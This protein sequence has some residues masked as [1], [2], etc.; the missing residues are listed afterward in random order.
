MSYVNE[1]KIVEAEFLSSWDSVATPVK[2]DNVQ[3]LVSGTNRIASE[4]KLAEWCQLSVVPGDAVQA[5][6]NDIKRVRSIGTIFVN[7][8]VKSGSGS[9]RIRELADEALQALQLKDLAT[10]FATRAGRLVNIGQA[11]NMSFYQM[12][13][14]VPYYHDYFHTAN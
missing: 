11:E 7:I 6:M 5:D 10:D 1:R 3:G 13:V 2:L 12:T 8:F 14:Q 9:D 4:A